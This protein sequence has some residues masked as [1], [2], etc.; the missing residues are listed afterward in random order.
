MRNEP[1]EYYWSCKKGNFVDKITCESSKWASFHGSDNEWRETAV[2]VLIDIRNSI[3]RRHGNSPLPAG[4]WY[5][6]ESMFNVLS[7]SCLFTMRSEKDEKRWGVIEYPF[8]GTHIIV[9]TGEWPTAYAS[10]RM[11]D[12]GRTLGTLHGL[13]FGPVNY[14]A[15]FMMLI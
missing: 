15:D 7:S 5:A 4:K 11:D 2:E 6:N 3:I 12:G 9:D 8:C 10:F 14:S 1:V 13:D